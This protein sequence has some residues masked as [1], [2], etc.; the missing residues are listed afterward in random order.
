MAAIND[1]PDKQLTGLCGEH[2]IAALLAGHG[3]IV[4]LPR[5]GAARSDLFVA[6]SKRGRAIRV[7][8]KAGRQSYWKY[9]HKYEGKAGYSWD[10]DRA[11]IKSHDEGLWYAFV[12]LG[13]W[14]IKTSVPVVF[15]V[16]SSIVA[17]RM[18]SHSSEKRPFFWDYEDGLKPYHGE[19]GIARLKI[20]IA[21]QG[22]ATSNQQSPRLF[23]NSPST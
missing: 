3:L 17:S 21:T 20:A 5:G 11:I 15:F 9:K 1:K 8:V 23:P 16:P 10:A 19:D 14:P 2:Y 7:Q 13:E 12:S 6:D 4:A 18:E 22:Q